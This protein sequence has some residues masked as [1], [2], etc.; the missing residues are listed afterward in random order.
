MGLGGASLDTGQQVRNP[1]R[2]EA[3]VLTKQDETEKEELAFFKRERSCAPGVS[4]EAYWGSLQA[5]LG[6]DELGKQEGGCPWPPTT[7]KSSLSTWLQRA[8]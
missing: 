2:E 3:R 6:T 7:E 8:Q 5:A 4:E 1:R